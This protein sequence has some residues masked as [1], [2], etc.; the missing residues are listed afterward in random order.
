MAPDAYNI[1]RRNLLLARRTLIRGSLGLRLLKALS[2]SAVILLVSAGIVLLAGAGSILTVFLGFAALFG[3]IALLML[4]VVLSFVRA[5]RLEAVAVMADEILP[6]RKNLVVSALQMGSRI[7]ELSSLYS[8][9]MMEAIVRQG[10]DL[11]GTL[12]RRRLLPSRDLRLWALR[13]LMTG[14]TLAAFLVFVP[15]A[16]NPAFSSLVLSPF[17]GTSSVGGTPV[18]PAPTDSVKAP[19][20]VAELTIAYE[21]PD[22]SGMERRAVR[23][24]V[25]DLVALKGTRV[26]LRVDFTREAR[27]ADLV[28]DN[29]NTLALRKESDRALSATFVVTRAG[30]YSIRARGAGGLESASPLYPI[31]VEEDFHPFIKLLAPPA[32]TDLDESMELPLEVFCADDYGLFS[33]YLHYF[34]DPGNVRKQ[35]IGSFR[36]RTRETTL[37]YFWDTGPLQLLPGESASYFLEVFDNDAVSG[38]KSARTPLM[39]ARFP[40]MAELYAGM[41]AEHSDQVVALEDILEEGRTLKEALDQLSM[42]MRQDAPVSW[43]KKKEIQGL[44]KA[45]SEMLQN[46]DRIGQALAEDVSRL[47]SHDPVNWELV[48]KIQELSKLLGEIQSPELRDAIDRLNAALAKLDREAMAEAMSQCSFSQE[49][50]LQGLDRAIELLKQIKQDEELRALVEEAMRLAEKETELANELEPSG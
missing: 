36:E 21:Y 20:Q 48:D 18:A 10:S 8:R 41:E 39:T 28:F 1:L 46:I 17:A 15:G 45:S 2:I 42:E 47:E 35:E 49:D 40:T 19:P 33:L 31:K 50:L 30:S 27:S 26:G 9:E 6:G 38:P 5:P 16:L 32:E 13:L 14:A 7:G 23:T 3:A 25:G 44:G 34:T 4:A 22:Y 43:E 11:S 29:G 24:V 12:E 37:T